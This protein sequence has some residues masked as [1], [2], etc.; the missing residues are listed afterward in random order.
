MHRATILAAAAVAAALVATVGNPADAAI[1]LNQD[2]D[3]G[4]LNVAAS[5]ATDALV[6]LEPRRFNSPMWSGNH[7]WVA[8]EASGLSGLT[9]TF[10]IPTSGAFQ[11]YSS[12]HRWVYSYD[13][14][15]TWSS[16]NNGL[17]SGGYYS[18]SNNTPFAADVARIA[19]AIPFPASLTTAYT[20][21]LVGNPYIFPTA[22]ADVGLVIGQTLGGIAGGYTDDLGRA[23]P[24]FDLYG[25][26][27]TDPEATGPKKKVVITTGNHSGEPT[28]TWTH[29]GFIDFALSNDPAAVELRQKAE[30]YVYPQTDP[31]GRWAGYFRSNPE[32][33]E[34][35]HNRFWHDPTGFTDLTIVIGAMRADTGV[36]VDPEAAVDFFF[37]FHSYGSA[38][39]IGYYQRTSNAPSNLYVSTLK[40]LESALYEHTGLSG[41]GA[42]STWAA[43]P[44]GLNATISLTPETGFLANQPVERYLTLGE[45]YARAVLLTINDW[46]PPPPPPVPRSE[47][48]FLDQVA[49]LGPVM[50]LR[51][52]ET[53]ANPAGQQ[54][55][56]ASGHNRHGVYGGNPR[57]GRDD[58]FD[59]SSGTAAKFEGMLSPGGQYV[60]IPDFDYTNA[61]NEFTLAFW[62]QNADISG[63]R[64]QYMFSHG[65]LTSTNSLN[66]Y[67][68]E[69][70]HDSTGSRGK[71]RTVFRD[72]NDPQVYE[73]FDFDAPLDAYW[74]LYTFVYSASE[75]AAIV[76]LD[77][78]EQRRSAT[79][80]GGAFNPATDIFLG[81]RF[82]LDTDRFYGRGA[83]NC[84][85]L[86]EV[87]LFN[88]ALGAEQIAD[89]AAS[90][91]PE[92]GVVAL[93]L[94]GLL[95]LALRFRRRRAA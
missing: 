13:D 40:G 1:V 67:V 62:F 37:D 22:S 85:L 61:Q 5:T 34:L 23:P 63:T 25:Y 26:V 81:S 32:N 28:G 42:A 12:A 50:H 20:Q 4:S 58:P 91:V 75:G 6:T 31:E 45:N 8:F 15:A 80:G 76:Y 11:G 78:V 7:W 83:E 36:A 82:D 43:S 39:G 16:F 93:A 35:N 74:H 71:L 69:T 9:P 70:G 44:G 89:L 90:P 54:A 95:G 38:T 49:A 19:I 72:D 64:T 29:Q 24:A 88:Y 66:I 30:I 68:V 59:V 65:N 55:A 51:L 53:Y 17:V 56:D 94:V 2:F 10:R 73:A 48:V 46:P 77:G 41:P 79:L 87:L 21:S 3:S 52:N 14:G 60:R 18:F 86:D 84:G 57:L 27:I 33:P 92:P 47:A